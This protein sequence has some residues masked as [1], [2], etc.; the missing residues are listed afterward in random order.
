VHKLFWFGAVAFSCAAWAD[1]ARYLRQ[2]QSVIAYASVDGGRTEQYRA[3]C[4]KVVLSDGEL[5]VGEL[6]FRIRDGALH[7]PS[8]RGR[9]RSYEL[10]DHCR[11]SLPPLYESAEQ[12]RA[13]PAETKPFDFGDCRDALARLRDAARVLDTATHADA[14]KTLAR[15]QRLIARGGTLYAH[16]DCR[17][18]AVK[19][20]A[21]GVTTTR[22]VIDDTTL[23]EDYRFEPLFGRATALGG[24][25]WRK[26]GGEGG[27]AG[28]YSVALLLGKDAFV[29]DREVLFFDPKQC[30]AP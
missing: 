24:R 15:F 13:V 23:E 20:P 26:G 28:P 16:P 12:C 7:S 1:E 14:E 10:R 19:R 3:S 4:E 6:R 9:E 5:E 2:Q 30:A 29:L 11:V 21:D 27:S 22:T 18:L 25:S 8:L 17:A